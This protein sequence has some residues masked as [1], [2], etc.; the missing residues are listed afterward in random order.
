[1]VAGLKAGQVHL[2]NRDADGVITA[3]TN[4]ADIVGWTADEILRV[5]MG[6]DDPTDAETA[7]A[8]SELRRLRDA[9]PY[10]DNR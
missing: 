10:P 8:A 7:M 2:I 3:S 9:G 4:T 1:M 5:F 6:V